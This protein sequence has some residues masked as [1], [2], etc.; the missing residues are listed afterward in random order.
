MTK[1]FLILIFFLA[2]TSCFKNNSDSSE[3]SV[4]QLDT[5]RIAIIRLDTT[6][7][8]IRGQVNGKQTSLKLSELQEI[9]PIF[10]D[11]VKEYN[12]NG[13]KELF[14]TWR[15][16]YDSVDAKLQQFKIDPKDYHRQYIGTINSSNQKEIYINCFIQD[17]DPMYR[18][19]DWK[20]SMAIVDGG[21]MGYFH[22]TI[23]LTTKEH[24]KVTVNDFE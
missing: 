23:N 17:D 24:S 13:A 15:Q 12:D 6:S 10:Q 1:V 3:S 22:L 18:H 2:L 11:A 7:E 4:P 20:S 21:G 5:S 19:N 8:Y 16:Y 9:E 14:R